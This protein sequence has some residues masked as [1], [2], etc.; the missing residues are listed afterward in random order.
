MDR[1]DG[2]CHCFVLLLVCHS[3]AWTKEAPI[4]LLPLD[5]AG[6]E[7]QNQSPF[8][9]SGPNV[10][11]LQAVYSVYSVCVPGGPWSVLH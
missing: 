9:D 1:V 8:R 6:G 3:S 7:D 2:L 5:E 10:P 4:F 11:E